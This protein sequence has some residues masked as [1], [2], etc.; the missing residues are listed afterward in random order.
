MKIIKNILGI[1]RKYH[2]NL[3]DT[4]YEW[5]VRLQ[6]GDIR[7]GELEEY[8][9]WIECHPEQAEGVETL[10]RM[11][12]QLATVD[13]E[14]PAS[15]QEYA[16]FR[17]SGIFRSFLSDHWFF[18]P[19]FQSCMFAGIAIIAGLLFLI[20]HTEESGLVY[21]T[22]RAEKTTI[23]LA[24]GS[25]AR[26]NVLSKMDIDF[27][28]NERHV[29]LSEG[30]VFFDVAPDSN[31]PFIVSV[32]DSEVYA[33]GTEFN[34]SIDSERTMAV[35]LV[36]GRIRVSTNLTNE[37]AV[38]SKI[39]SE[40]G[41]QAK[42]FQS[43]VLARRGMQQ[44]LASLIEVSNRELTTELAWRDEK[45]IF[46]GETLAEAIERINR[47]TTHTIQILDP[48]IG[49]ELKVY[50]V[51]NSGDWEGFISGIELSYPLRAER[52]R[53]DVTVLRSIARN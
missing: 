7:E 39:L 38:T 28:D 41:E 3:S 22:A 2:R 17:K 29:N 33:L 10:V 32:D 45:L 40:P 31:R 23:N 43:P 36:E 42:I 25:I 8:L 48:A 52:V 20:S 15:L 37:Q 51:F 1:S 4:A 47:H 46:E 50:G 24:D 11:W 49:E 19:L 13:I 6:T 16:G 12:E 34:V 9:D 53:P 14:A 21:Q 18:Q 5:A 35:T 44:D 26:M 27:S 30:E